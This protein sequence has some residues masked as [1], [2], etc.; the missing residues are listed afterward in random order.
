[1][2]HVAAFEILIIDDGRPL[3]VKLRILFPFQLDK[4][5]YERLAVDGHGTKHRGRRVIPIR[6]TGIRRFENTDDLK[7]QHLSV[8]R[9]HF[10]TGQHLSDHKIQEDQGPFGNDDLDD[11][12]ILD[13]RFIHAAGRDLDVILD[14]TV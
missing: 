7:C 14:P 11:M 9:L 12:A 13:T 10:L 4:C 5:F 2:L 8:R 6:I 1:M 3:H